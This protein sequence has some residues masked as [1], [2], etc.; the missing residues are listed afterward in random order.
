MFKNSPFNTPSSSKKSILNTSPSVLAIFSSQ[1][2]THTHKIPY[3][4]NTIEF[5]TAD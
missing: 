5:H 2:K 3:I 4:Y 1:C